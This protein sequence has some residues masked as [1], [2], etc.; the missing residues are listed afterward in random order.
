MTTTLD[1]YLALKRGRLVELARRL[2]VTPQ[3]LCDIR[4]GRRVPSLE[5]AV[6][7]QRETGVPVESFI[8]SQAA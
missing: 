1:T 4:K 7:I 8:K 3:R 5:L 2:N 6:A